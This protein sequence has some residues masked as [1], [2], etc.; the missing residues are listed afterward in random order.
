MVK[1]RFKID[2]YNYQNKTIYKNTTFFYVCKPQPS[3]YVIFNICHNHENN[4]TINCP[5]LFPGILYLLFNPVLVS[6]L[7]YFS[8]SRQQLLGFAIQK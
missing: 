2:E 4:L 6:E 5:G 1:K 3:F 7:C 8:S